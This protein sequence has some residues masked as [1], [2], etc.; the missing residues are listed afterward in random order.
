MVF[1]VLHAQPD[2]TGTLPQEPSDAQADKTGVELLASHALVEDNGTLLQSHVFALLEAGMDSLA[3]NVPLDKPGTPQAI[4]AHAHQPLFG[5]VLIAEHAQAQSGIGTIN[6][7]I[8]FAELETGTEPNV[9]FAQLAQ[10]GTERSVSLVM[11]EEFGTH[12][13]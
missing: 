3:F 4:H 11:V 6:L 10:T 8:V 13:M 9:S 7:T 2:K 5:T 1:N 12:W